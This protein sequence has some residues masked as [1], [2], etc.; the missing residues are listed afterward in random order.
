M[1]RK[2]KGIIV[3]R[4]IVLL[5]IFLVPI[6]IFI[7]FFLIPFQLAWADEQTQFFLLKILIPLVFSISWV[8]FLLIFANR[9]ASSIDMMDKTIGV[10]PLRL[11]F[12]YGLNAIFVLLILIYPLVTPIISVLAFAS[13]AWRLTTFRREEWDEQSKTSLLTKIAVI[14]AI[15]LPVVCGIIIIPEIITLSIYLWN[16]IWVPLLDYIYIISRALCTALAIGSLIIIF[17]KSGIS[18]YEQLYMKPDDAS[19]FMGVKVFDAFCFI[20]FIFL[21]IFEIPIIDLF[22]YAGFVIVCFV[23]LAN[24]IKGKMEDRSF[25]SYILGYLIAIVF[26]GSSLITYDIGPIFDL[27]NTIKTWSLILSAVIFILIFFITFLK[28]EDVES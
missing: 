24:L 2:I 21:E 1:S 9:T 27:G 18:E 20:F 10:V 25:K 17:K 11:K 7:I 16:N 28:I 8:Y 6:L 15:I 26:M 12:F 3:S 4:L 22:Y 5:S 23:A 13:F 19:F 14:I